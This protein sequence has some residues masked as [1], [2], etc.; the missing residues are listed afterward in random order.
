[1]FGFKVNRWINVI[2]Y[3][4]RKEKHIDHIHMCRILVMMLANQITPLKIFARKMSRQ[5][6]SNRLPGC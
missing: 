6:E 3:M 2:D 1:M 5:M 4:I